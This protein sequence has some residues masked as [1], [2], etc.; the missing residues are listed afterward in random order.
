M[1]KNNQQ[2]AQQEQVATTVS[3]VEEF[4]KKNQKV[5]EWVLIAIIVIILGILA[6]NKW[7]LAPAKQEAQGQ[8]F[9]A[10]Q[11]FRDGNFE[12]A[13]NGDGN[14][15][16]FNQ[17]IDQYGKKGGKSVYF[18]AGICNLQLGNYQEAIDLLRK[19]STKDKVMQGRTLC[20]IGDAYCNLQDYTNALANYKNAAAVEENAFAATYLLKAGL[21]CEETGD[22]DGALKFY[23][24][25]ETKYPQTLE[26][27]DIQKYIARIENS[28]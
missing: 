24:E 8:M 4:F 20:A 10:E 19:Y 6:Y 12:A 14:I 3:G 11:Q 15:L 7:V 13:L 21:V 16:G 22:M 27:Y 5:I 28:K 25:I 1:A 23:K 18:Y 9:P 17:I 2:E 26:G